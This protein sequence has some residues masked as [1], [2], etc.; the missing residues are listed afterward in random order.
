M[1]GERGRGEGGRRSSCEYKPEG[2]GL[3]LEYQLD[4]DSYVE[5]KASMAQ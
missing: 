1:N 2:R 3:K 5:D 4:M